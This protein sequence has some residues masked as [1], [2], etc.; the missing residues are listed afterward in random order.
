MSNPTPRPTVYLRLWFVYP[1]LVPFY[2]L[3][4]TLVPGTQHVASGVPQLADFYLLGVMAYVF[5]SLPF[6]LSRPL[7]PVVCAL[8]C[9]A[10]YATLVNLTWATVLEDLSLFQSPLF[11]CYDWALFLLFVT[12]Y[13]TFKDQFLKVTVHSVAV[14]VLLQAA[15][16]PLASEHFGRQ[17]LFFNDENQLGYFCLLAAIIFILGARR[18]LLPLGYQLLVYGAL[19]YLA[20]L[21]QCRSA[22]LALG[23]LV[24]VALLGRPLRFLLAIAAISGIYFIITLEPSLVGQYRDRFVTQG[25]YDTLSTRGY[26]RIVNHPEHVVLGAGE[27]AYRRFR[28]DLYGTEL[29]SSYGTL[30]FCYGLPGTSFFVLGLLLICKRDLM[31]ALYLLPVFV[32]GSAHQG[33]RFAFFWTMLA[34]LC[35]L[36]LGSE[37]AAATEPEA[38]PPPDGPAGGR[39]ATEPAP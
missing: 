34:F 3:G 28:S 20:A 7:V 11:Y 1:L 21:S 13:S 12:L 14:S 9:F 24:L 2:L 10:G 8:G 29:H 33:L 22:L 26:D 5:T 18:F 25:E 15:L 35:C 19:G 37:P 32:Y 16:S 30:L 36:A 39:I 6:R 4:K 38:S 27:G 23:T 31:Y 17:S